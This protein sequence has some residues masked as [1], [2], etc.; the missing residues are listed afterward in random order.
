MYN[1]I[2]E[3]FFYDPKGYGRLECK[4][5]YLGVYAY[6]YYCKLVLAHQPYEGR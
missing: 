2:C 4:V 3:Y 6:K 1:L 5:G